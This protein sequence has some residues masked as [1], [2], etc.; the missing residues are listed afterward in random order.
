MKIEGKF[1]HIVSKELSAYYYNRRLNNESVHSIDFQAS[2]TTIQN[3]ST[4]HIV[5]QITSCDHVGEIGTLGGTHWVG[6]V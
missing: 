1:L 6:V 5:N 2:L 4:T 3:R